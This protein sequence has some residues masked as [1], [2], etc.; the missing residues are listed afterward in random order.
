[1]VVIVEDRNDNAPVFQNT[2]YSTRINE[3]TSALTGCVCRMQTSHRSA[4]S[5]KDQR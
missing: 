4:Q 2:D 1:M 5:G 3:V